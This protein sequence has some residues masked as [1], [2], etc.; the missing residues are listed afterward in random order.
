MSAAPPALP[1]LPGLPGTFALDTF[2]LS[3]GIL[4]RIYWKGQDPLLPAT[5]G[6]NRYDCPLIVP[7]AN[8]FGVLYLGY[9]FETCWM[10]TVVRESIIRPAGDPLRIRAD[11]MTDRW[12]CEVQ[13]AGTLTIANFADEALLDLGESASNIMGDG[14]PR[15]QTWSKL[16][17]AHANPEVDG[18]QY[19][20][21]FKSGDF[22]IALFD[23]G[24]A[25]GNL[26]LS[27]ERSIDPASSQQIQSI[28]TR[29]KVIPY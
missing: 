16:L 2:T 6:K 9:R 14:Y 17:L 22:C 1:T 23:R 5:D 21:R 28:M 29:F 7:K 20:S 4:H 26:T 11:N 27:N 12:A 25:R 18:I 19:R 10:E 13:V 15:T 3:R 8:R 24:I